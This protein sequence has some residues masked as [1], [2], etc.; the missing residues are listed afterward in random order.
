MTLAG[1]RRPT[2]YDIRLLQV[3]ERLFAEFDDLPIPRVLR[4]I[5][6]VRSTMRELGQL[7]PDPR[8]V[9]SIARD[10]LQQSR[11]SRLSEVP[12]EVMR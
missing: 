3:A 8:E 7:V 9:E 11:Y 10:W 2:A 4:T 5:N 6:W 12:V 1:S